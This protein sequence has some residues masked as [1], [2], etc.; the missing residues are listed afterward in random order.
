[1][2]ETLRPLTADERGILEGM[3]RARP[4]G[5][6]ALGAFLAFLVALGVLLILAPA[7]WEVGALSLIPTAGAFAFALWVFARLR[8]GERRSAWLA[9]VER[10]LA[11]GVASVVSARVRDA[12][13][14]EESEDEGSSYYLE[15]DDGRVLFL[16]G[17]YLYDVEE[18]GRFPNTRVTVARAPATRIVLGVTC[19]GSAFEPSRTRAPFTAGEYER[20]R[21]PEDGAVVDVDFASLRGARSGG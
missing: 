20:G 3:R 4:H 6:P 16:S 1:V 11:G 12:V 7:S 10:D 8:G 14:V 9:R 21:V 17:Q 19:D 18:E 5:S 2:D 15:L 13:R